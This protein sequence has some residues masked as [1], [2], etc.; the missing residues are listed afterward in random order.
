MVP[1]PVPRHISFVIFGRVPL[2]PFGYPR[3]LRNPEFSRS[4]SH[5]KMGALSKPSGVQKRARV[6]RPECRY[7]EHA[8]R[9]LPEPTR[10]SATTLRLLPEPTRGSAATLR[11]LE[12]VRE[13]PASLRSLPEPTRAS[14]EAE[15]IRN[16]RYM[17]SILSGAA[18]N[19]FPSNSQIGLGVV[20]DWTTYSKWYTG[21]KV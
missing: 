20:D 16:D 10:G 19:A 18:S 21:G 9:L 2:R 15:A 1:E 14:L 11:L 8:L 17:L 6:A 7:P 3:P 12:P 13:S 5:P 4:T